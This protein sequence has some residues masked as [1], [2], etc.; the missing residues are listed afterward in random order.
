MS[1]DTF[2]PV[3]LLLSALS[4]VLSLVLLVRLGR[5]AA[6]DRLD[7]VETALSGV[8]RGQERAERV[9]AESFALARRESA[10]S[11]RLLREEVSELITWLSDTLLAQDA[12]STKEGREQ[13]RQHFELQK[14]QHTALEQRLQGLGET[15]GRSSEALRQAI[16]GQLKT[17][18]EE[19]GQKLEQMRVTVDEKLQGTLEKRLGESFKHVS[20]RLE[21]VHKGLGEM[22]TLATGVGDLKRV[23]TNVKARG[24]WGEVQLGALLEQILTPSQYIRNAVMAPSGAER[25]EFAVVLPGHGEGEQVFLPID[26]KFPIEDYERLQ[27]AAELGDLEAVEIAGRALEAR[28]K[29]SARDISGKYVYPPRTTDFAIMFLPTEGLFAEAIRRPGLIDDLQRNLR[30][31]VAGPTTLTA[32]LNSLQMGFRTLAIQKRSSEVWQV[33]GAVKAE[34]DKFGPVL[35]RVKKKLQEASNHIESAETRNRAIGKRLRQVQDLPTTDTMA[36][37]GAVDDEHRWE[38]EDAPE[39]GPP[40]TPDFFDDIEKAG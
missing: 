26:A 25:V 15:Q 40:I 5:V 32:L 28:L 22:Q 39:T 21:A 24:S 18:R 6:P 2:I 7:S 11:A 16:E 8:E 12:A 33:L 29:A 38:T 35:E 3:S 37:L 30:V 13:A 27:A 31:V 20:D 23:L 4:I 36:L 17:L 10:E 9:A 34:F 14:G 19:N 1:L